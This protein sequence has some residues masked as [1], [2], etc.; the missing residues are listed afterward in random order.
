[1]S[2][3]YVS[4]TINGDLGNI[5]AMFNEE[6]NGISYPLRFLGRTS[7]P[8]LPFFV[9]LTP[10]QNND[11]YQERPTLTQPQVERVTRF[12]A[13]MAQALQA[14]FQQFQALG[15]TTLAYRDDDGHPVTQPVFT[16]DQTSFVHLEDDTLGSSDQMPFTFAGV[17]CAT[18][19]GDANY[20]DPRSPPW[21]YPYD[22]PE[23]TIQL[24]NTYASGRSIKSE[25][26]VLALALPGMMT[27][28]MLA[29]PEILGAVPT[30]GKPLSALSDVSNTPRVHHV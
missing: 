1:G 10:L 28:W 27:A 7:N 16:A 22:Q 29:Q 9:D 21:G 5:V 26:L 15:Y 24:M 14:A 13:L 20:Y 11:L 2:Y 6:Q 3:H 19:V 30:D 25:A 17:A 23:D 12:R 4:S 18:L 8:V